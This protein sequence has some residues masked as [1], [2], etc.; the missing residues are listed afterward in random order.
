MSE[1]ILIL[2]RHLGE[3]HSDE[4]ILQSYSEMRART[5][6]GPAKIYVQAPVGVEKRYV[7]KA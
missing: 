5:G 1:R 6:C 4:E 2:P 7:G 3:Q